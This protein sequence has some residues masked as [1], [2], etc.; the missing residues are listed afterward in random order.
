MPIPKTNA[1]LLSSQT[2]STTSPAANIAS[3]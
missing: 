1:N 3:D 2:T